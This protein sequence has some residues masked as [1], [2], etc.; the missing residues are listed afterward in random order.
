MQNLKNVKSKLYH[1]ETS[2]ANSVDL[3]E[4]A[5]FEPPHQDY[6][7][8]RFRYFRLWYL[9]VKN[10]IDVKHSAIFLSEKCE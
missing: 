4:V 8:C 3:D 7:V 2:K 10:T 6:A 5:H 9:G 1:I